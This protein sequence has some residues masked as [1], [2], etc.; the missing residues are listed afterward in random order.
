MRLMTKAFGRVF[1]FLGVMLA[2]CAVGSATAVAGVE[3]LSL[4]A[5]DGHGAHED[6]RLPSA[7][8]NLPARGISVDF[9]DAGAV[10][11]GRVWTWTLKNV[12]ASPIVDLR[13]TVFLD[14]DQSV[15][16]N[17]FFNEI[18]ALLGLSAPSGHIAADRWEIS[19]PGYWSGNLLPRAATGDLLNQVIPNPGAEND[20]AMALSMAAGTLNPGQTVITGWRFAKE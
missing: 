17:T 8:G 12:S 7:L 1:V 4:F 19:E 15:S 16:Q 18:G 11:G 20:V 6:Q 2:M 14:A 3:R 5:S 13:L 9:S 10:P